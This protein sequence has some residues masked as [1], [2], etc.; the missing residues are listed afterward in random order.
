MQL[1]FDL[2]V[3]EVNIILNSLAAQPY[4]QVFAVMEKLKGSANAQ[5]MK[6]QALAAQ[7]APTLNIIPANEE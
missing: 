7:N 4:N 2:S 3:D 6:Q 5:I 1:N